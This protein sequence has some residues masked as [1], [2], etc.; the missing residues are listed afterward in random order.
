V[1]A[2]QEKEVQAYGLAAVGK[3][4]TNGTGHHMHQMHHRHM[5]SPRVHITANPLAS[6]ADHYKVGTS[7]HAHL[8]AIACFLYVAHISLVCYVK[9]II[10]VYA[11]LNAKFYLLF[12][13]YQ[14]NK[15]LQFKQE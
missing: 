11:I 14:E 15:P 9:P 1:L 4:L 10:C 8:L 13:M 5:G 3:P 12:I 6:A 7:L 2:D